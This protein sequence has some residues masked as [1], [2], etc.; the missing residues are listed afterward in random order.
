MENKPENTDT[1]VETAGSTDDKRKKK[2]GLLLLITLLV[3]LMVGGSAFFVKHPQKLPQTLQ[4]ALNLDSAQSDTKQEKAS[5][6]A[7]QESIQIRGY[8]DVQL[9]VQATDMHL[10]LENP[11]GN[12]CYIQFTIRQVDPKTGAKGEV[13]YESGDVAP[14]KFINDQTLAHGFEQGEYP[15]VIENHTKSLDKSHTA[16]NGMD[17]HTKLIVN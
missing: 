11:K 13:L 2:R 17:V 12:P 10:A 8:P 4:N 14:G 3:L 9:K 7:K 1:L 15:I 16:M 6:P 5:T